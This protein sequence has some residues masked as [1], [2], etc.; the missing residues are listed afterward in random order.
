MDYQ[1]A[2]GRLQQRIAE[3]TT[4]YEGRMV[5][6]HAEYDERIEQLEARIKELEGGMVPEGQAHHHGEGS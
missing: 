1:K 6:I 3:I 4:E 2:A 5:F